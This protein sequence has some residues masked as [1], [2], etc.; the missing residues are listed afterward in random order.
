MKDD[1]IFKA[2]SGFGGGIGQMND[3]CGSLL[4]ASMVLS[5][6]FGRGLEEIEDQEKVKSSYLPVARLYKWFEKEFGSPTCRGIRT[7]MAGGVFYDTKIPWQKEMA[8]EAGLQAMCAELVAK[9]AA[10]TA[11]ILWD[12]E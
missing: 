7:S 3:V 12:A 10:H 5:M 8:D 9:T 11:E 2:A 6:K 1:S 4:G